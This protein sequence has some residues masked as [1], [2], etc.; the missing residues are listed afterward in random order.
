MLSIPVSF[1]ITVIIFSHRFIIVT[2]SMYKI[3]RKKSER[4]RKRLATTITFTID[5]KSK[6]YKIKKC[7]ISYV[8]YELYNSLQTTKSF[9]LS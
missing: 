9:T 6:I 4:S 7:S 5:F 1:C 8:S 3:K 2:E